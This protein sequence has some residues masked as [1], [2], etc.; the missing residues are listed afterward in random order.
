MSQCD[1]SEDELVISRLLF[2]C[3]Y[4][5]TVDFGELISKNSLLDSIIYVSLP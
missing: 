3:T 2:Y 4:N 5:T 1:S